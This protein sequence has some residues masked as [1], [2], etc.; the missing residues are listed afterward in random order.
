MRA[1]GQ[2]PPKHTSLLFFFFNHKT[3]LFS[4]S[5]SL[6]LP[7]PWEFPQDGALT[8]MLDWPSVLGTG[9]V[10]RPWPQN[11]DCPVLW[12]WVSSSTYSV[13]ALW[14]ASSHPIHSGLTQ[15]EEWPC[16]AQRQWC[17]VPAQPSGSWERAWLLVSEQGGGAPWGKPVTCLGQLVLTSHRGT[18]Y[19]T[20]PEAHCSLISATHTPCWDAFPEAHSLWEHTK[21]QHPGLLQKHSWCSSHMTWRL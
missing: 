5:V 3:A 21:K 11:Y 15:A 9:E 4:L 1:H 14:L 7:R 17:P 16:S 20:K 8:E 12:A 18:V 13:R 10:R 6:G 2:L 19:P